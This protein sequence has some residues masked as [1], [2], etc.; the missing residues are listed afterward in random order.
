MGTIGKWLE[1][2]KPLLGMLLVQLI[3]TG[4]QILSRVILSRGTFVFSLLMYRHIVAAACILP[5]ALYFERGC[6]KKLSLMVWIWLFLSALSG[7]TLGMGLFYYGMR[8]TNATFA[9][10]F[11][12][13]I[14]VV[15]FVFS[16]ILGMEKLDLRTKKGKMKV[17]GAILCVAGAATIS[18]Y[19]GKSLHLFHQNFHKKS[20]LGKK[21]EPHWTTG[22]CVLAG[23]VFAYACWFIVQVKL[24][25]V[26][27]YKYW[28]TMFTCLM[29]CAQ[30]AVIGVCIDR[31]K[32]SWVLGWNLELITV[33][34][35]GVLASAVSFCLISMAIR[36]RGPTYP[37]MFNPLALIFIAI[38][39]ALF[40]GEDLSVGSLL[41]MFL[42][43][44]GLYAFLWG[45]RSTKPSSQPLPEI[46]NEEI[47]KNG[48]TVETPRT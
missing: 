40:L 2:S 21:V 44:V 46:V 47:D 25:T 41:G 12:N 16:A 20:L 27:P 5:F 32:A 45:K 39:E 48:S 8:A 11:L 7:I 33:L 19:K 24:L 37:P 9:T 4:L 31:R 3:M 38:L 36:M 34:Y 17:L 15:T 28:A 13:L 43:I 29:V 1:E 6:L 42:I 14:P 26:F 18:L 10:D 23:S 22:I 30:A 35:S